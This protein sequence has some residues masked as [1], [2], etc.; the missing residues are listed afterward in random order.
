M[1][2]QLNPGVSPLGHNQEN[3]TFVSAMKLTFSA[4]IRLESNLPPE[5]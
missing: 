5:V 4:K 1:N 2:R 3:L